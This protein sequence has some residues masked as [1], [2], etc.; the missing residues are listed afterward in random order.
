MIT[1]NIINY[2]SSEYISGFKKGLKENLLSRLNPKHEII[3]VD[4]CSD[5]GSF[6]ELEKIA[7]TA[8]QEE[9]NRGEA[10]N[11]CLQLSEGEVLLDQLDTDQIAQPIL[12]D[13]VNWYVEEMPEYCLLTNGTMINRRDIVSGIGWGNYQ[14]GEDKYLWDRLIEKE[15]CKFLDFNTAKH[16]KEKHRSFFS[17]VMSATYT[18]KEDYPTVLSE[19]RDTDLEEKIETW[20]WLNNRAEESEKSDS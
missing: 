13:I 18:P 6:E 20:R 2:N 11:L 14:F 19:I 10:R 4:N 5:D 8:V 9:T 3:V 1:I 12:A 15:K 17:R 7:D 16:I